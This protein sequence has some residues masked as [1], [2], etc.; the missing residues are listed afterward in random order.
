MTLSWA[1]AIQPGLN[2]CEIDPMPC[3]TAID[4]DP[5]S[6]AVGFTKSADAKGLSK[7]VT[8]ICSSRVPVVA[9]NMS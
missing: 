4:D 2:L 6:A 3:R 1:P 9:E 8:H 5:D 7:A